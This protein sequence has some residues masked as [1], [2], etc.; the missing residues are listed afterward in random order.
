MSA[1][2]LALVACDG[3]VIQADQPVD[4]ISRVEAPTLVEARREAGADG[5]AV[6][7]PGPHDNSD[8]RDLCPVH[9]H[10]DR[11][12]AHYFSWVVG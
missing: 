4:C 7:Q 8:R 3:L 6:N 2:R 9:R 5:W 1:Q 12:P 10:N 11:D